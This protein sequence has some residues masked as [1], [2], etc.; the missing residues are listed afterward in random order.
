MHW[1]KAHALVF[2]EGRTLD[3]EIHPFKPGMSLIETD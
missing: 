3:G 1:T 2:P